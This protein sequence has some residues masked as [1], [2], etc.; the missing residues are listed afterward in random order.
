MKMIFVECLLLMFFAT[1]IQ[2]VNLDIELVL[3]KNDVVPEII[4]VSPH[5]TLKI[6]YP[7]GYYVKAGNIMKTI[8]VAEQPLVHWKTDPNKRDYYTIVMFSPDYPTRSNSILANFLHW[9]VVNIPG[10]HVEDG[11]VICDYLGALPEPDNDVHRYIFIVY[12]QK[13]KTNYGNEERIYV[14]DFSARE[15]F[16]IKKLVKKYLLNP[17]AGNIFLAEFDQYSASMGGAFS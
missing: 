12:K 2:S 6:L 14:D 15:R 5:T 8:D 16:S 9:M 11:E 4:D 17:V 13:A 7:N 1:V 10:G 3:V